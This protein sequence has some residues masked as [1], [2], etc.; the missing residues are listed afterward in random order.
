MSPPNLFLPKA[1]LNPVR[2][3]S[4]RRLDVPVALRHAEVLDLVLDGVEQNLV[5]SHGWL[6]ANEVLDPR[7]IGDT[8]H[9]VLKALLIRFFIRNKNDGR[10]RSSQLLN[11]MRQSKNRNLF[12]RS[13]IADSAVSFALLGERNQSSRSVRYVGK[14]AGLRTVSINGHLPSPERLT[15]QTGDHHPVASALARPD[16]V[17]Q[18]RDH[19]RD[20]LFLPISYRQKFVDGFGARVTPAAFIGRAHH[21]IVALPEGNV[22]ALA[23]N[24]RGG[25]D[26]YSLLFF[27]GQLQDN[28]SATNVSFHRADW[29]FNDEADTNGRSQMIDNIRSVNQ[30]RHQGMVGDGVKNVL[31]VLAAFQVFDILNGSG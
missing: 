13:N 5:Q 10:F 7:Q 18:A 17:E 30:F 22:I 23:V 12:H 29:R 6:V 11:L 1:E 9:H 21:Q 20:F 14:A 27:G 3:D 15:N 28:L 31:E 19:G 8:P 16:Y 24:L 25:S 4:S 26:Q 2:Y